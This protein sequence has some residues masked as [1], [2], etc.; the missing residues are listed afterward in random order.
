[1]KYYTPKGGYN[2]TLDWV[3]E[4]PQIKYYSN[5]VLGFLGLGF[6]V[7]GYLEGQGYL[8]NNLHKGDRLAMWLN[9]GL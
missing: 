3:L 7:Q 1:M 8:V 2:L 6:A 9:Y 5:R 4:Y